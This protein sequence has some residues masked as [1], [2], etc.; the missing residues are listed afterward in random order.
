MRPM[1]ANQPRIVGFIW[2]KSCPGSTGSLCR[3]FPTRCAT[4]W[5]NILSGWAGEKKFVWKKFILAFPLL[6]QIVFFCCF[7]GERLDLLIPRFR[8][9]AFQT[10]SFVPGWE[11]IPNYAWR[12][13][14]DFIFMFP[15]KITMEAEIVTYNYNC[16]EF[17]HTAIS[18]TR[19]LCRR[20]GSEKMG[21]KEQSV[22]ILVDGFKIVGSHS[23]KR[24]ITKR[25]WI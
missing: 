3:I 11:W 14:A 19:K 13:H 4:N 5:N 12:L 7:V 23:L 10:G 25:V 15:E 21:L 24:P 1:S 17:R 20:E 6:I 2:R 18:N 8:L 9:D 22:G 16:F